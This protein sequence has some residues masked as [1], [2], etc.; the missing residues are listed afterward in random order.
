MNYF[1][2]LIGSIFT[3]ALVAQMLAYAASTKKNKVEVRKS[4]KNQA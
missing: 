3:V 1:Y 2:I 4:R